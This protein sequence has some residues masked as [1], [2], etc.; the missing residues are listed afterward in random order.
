MDSSRVNWVPMFRRT[1]R[2][3]PDFVPP[4]DSP[5]ARNEMQFDPS[6][7]TA[8]FLAFTQGAESA[9]LRETQDPLDMTEA[10]GSLVRFHRYLQNV[11]VPMEGTP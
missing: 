1:L 11:E 10:I 5:S 4:I 8:Q 6:A 2:N 9:Y 3:F 7:H